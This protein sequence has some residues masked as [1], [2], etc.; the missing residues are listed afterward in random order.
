[1]PKI[2]N[3]P[4]ERILY[5][6]YSGYY[7]NEFSY[8]TDDVPLDEY[9]TYKQVTYRYPLDVIDIKVLSVD[10]LNDSAF[11]DVSVTLVDS[12]GNETVH[13]QAL[14]VY[15]TDGRWIKPTVSVSKYQHEYEDK[16]R[17]AIEE[18]EEE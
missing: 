7:E 9:L 17:K 5:E 10:R 1:M 3:E 8:L 14:T 6:D 15:Y 13:D 4:W 12:V 18:A 11:V 2:L 16:I